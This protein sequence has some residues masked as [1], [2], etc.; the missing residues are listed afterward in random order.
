MR[1]SKRNHFENTI[2]EQENYYYL[3]EVQDKIAA[4]E[5]DVHEIEEQYSL[6][7]VTLEEAIRKNRFDD[8]DEENGGVWIERETRI[9]ELLLVESKR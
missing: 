7:F 4:P 3:C 5:F 1:L 2:F 9:M 8:H 6:V